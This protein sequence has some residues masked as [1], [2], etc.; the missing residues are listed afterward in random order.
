M[1][2]AYP[3]YKILA[4]KLRYGKSFVKL[5]VTFYMYYESNFLG[6]YF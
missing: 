6:L 3:Q 1:S 5:I 2:I 4:G